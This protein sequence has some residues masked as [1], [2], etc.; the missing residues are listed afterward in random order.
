M[1]QLLLGLG[2][3][4][5][6]D[7]VGHGCRRSAD[8]VDR[9]HDGVGEEAPHQLVDAVVQRGREQQPLSACRGGR[10][11]AG[12]TGQ[13]A[14]IGHVVSLVEHGCDDVV[15][16]DQLLTHQVLEAPRACHDDV[17]AR[18]QRG[19]LLVLGDPAEDGGHT[20]PARRSQRLQHSG[21][22]GGQFPGGGQH[23]AGGSI[24]PA[25]V[26]AQCGHQRYRER[27]RL[28]AAGL[29]AAEH[30][31]ARQRIGQRRGLDGKRCGDVVGGQRA[32][33]R[34]GH[35]EICEGVGGHVC[36]S[37]VRAVCARLTATRFVQR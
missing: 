14:E 28:A 9:V 26:F 27:Q 29:T 21:D 7:V 1:H 8:L 32:H 17:G 36:L 24:R 12:D 16:R 4:D 30:V 31:T 15:E 37:G 2:S 10:Q 23:E 34:C 6:E 3:P 35:A 13:E 22:L 5:V 19:D 18:A 20:Q 25:A 33:Q 11:D